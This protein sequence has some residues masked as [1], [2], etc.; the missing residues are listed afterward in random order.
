[1]ADHRRTYEVLVVDDDFMVAEIHTRFVDATPGFRAAG[2]AHTASDAVRA[3]RDTAPD[4]VLL[5]VYL[6]DRSGLDALAELRS[7]G[8]GVAVIVITAARELDTV[9]R[10][11]HGGAADYLVKPFE[12]P[13][14][15]EKLENFRRRAQ[16]LAD[17]A[18]IDQTAID[19]LFGSA[20]PPTVP[21]ALPKGLSTETARL[22][23]DTVRATGEVSA[24]E[25]A[26]A[27]GLSRVSVRRYLEYLAS[28]GALDVRLEYG[29][30][31]RP[32]HRYSI[33]AM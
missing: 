13:Q 29:R 18:G 11:L 17:P 10:A 14:L 9:S 3:V 5:D 7:E 30:A 12:Y 6:P 19:S 31:G 16:T 25:C 4:L 27:A 8:N 28:T 1:M 15:L 21:A 2:T 24:S 20:R 23:L 26:E 22:V 33:S 32:V